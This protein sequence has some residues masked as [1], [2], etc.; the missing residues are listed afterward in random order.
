MRGAAQDPESENAPRGVVRGLLAALAAV[1]AF[2]FTLCAGSLRS[3]E[4]AR[5]ALARPG[6][7]G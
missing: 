7:R 6:P 4:V 3:R 2:V 1:V 5:P